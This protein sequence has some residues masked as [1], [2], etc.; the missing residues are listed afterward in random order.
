MIWALLS[1]L[2]VLNLRS[3]A[4]VSSHVNH[5][6]IHKWSTDWGLYYSVQC[7]ESDAVTFAEAAKLR[8]GRLCGFHKMSSC[9]DWAEWHKEYLSLQGVHASFKGCYLPK[10][11]VLNTYYCN[12]L[13][14][15]DL[16]ILP[17]KKTPFYLIYF[18]TF[19]IFVLTSD[20]RYPLMWNWHKA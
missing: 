2:H 15:I 19:E 14:Q 4:L 8:T 10:K 3:H 9:L 5:I 13:K 11:R 17:L 18:S 7:Q 20:L 12:I 6:G 16:W 1:F